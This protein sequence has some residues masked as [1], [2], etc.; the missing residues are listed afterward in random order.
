MSGIDNEVRNIQQASRGEDVRDSIV[1]ALRSLYTLYVS[2]ANATDPIIDNSLNRT[3]T[4]AVENRAIY[5]ALQ[6][7]RSSIPNIVIDDELSSTSSNPLQN[8]EIYAALNEIRAL[9]HDIIIDESLSELSENPVQNKVIA[10]ALQE[11]EASIPASLTVDE[12]IDAT[13]VNPI[14]NSAVSSALSRLEAL[15][16][17]PVTIDTAL[18][19]TSTNPVANYIIRNAL[20]NLQNQIPSVDSSIS[21]SSSNPVQNRAIYLALQSLSNSIPPRITID[22]SLNGNSTNP[23]SN[24][25]IFNKFIEL[26]N[27]IDSSI[28][29][30]DSELDLNSTN[31]VENRAINAA[32]EDILASI[33]NVSG[34]SVDLY[35]TENSANLVES[36]GVYSAIADAKTE[37]EAELTIV[38]D[39]E[40][41]TT[42]TNAVQNRIIAG[43]INDLEDDIMA[44]LSDI[45]SLENNISSDGSILYHPDWNENDTAS[46]RYIANRPFYTDRNG[47]AVKIPDKYLPEQIGKSGAG[48]MAELFNGAESASGWYSHAE[49][50]GTIAIGRA[51][52]VFGA[53]NI[54]DASCI[55]IV[56]NGSFINRSNARTLDKYGN[57]HLSGGI[58]LDT[59]GDSAKDVVT[60][61]KLKTLFDF[62]GNSETSNKYPVKVQ[63]NLNNGSWTNANT[64]IDNSNVYMSDA[65]SYHVNNG[66]S[67]VTISFSGYKKF[68]VVIWASSELYSDYVV[69]GKLDEYYIPRNINSTIVK[70]STYG[71]SSH[72]S[73]VYDNIDGLEHSIEIIYTKDGSVNYG[74]D[75]GYF[76]IDY[77]ACEEYVGTGFIAAAMSKL[78]DDN[79]VTIDTELNGESANPVQNSAVYEAI[80]NLQSAIPIVDNSISDTSVNAVQ[81]KA[82]SEAITSL[83]ASLRASFVTMLSNEAQIVDDELDTT[84]TNPVQN[85]VIATQINDILALIERIRQDGIS[86]FADASLNTNSDNP[87]QNSAVAI[88]LNEI[89]TS[90]STISSSLA[91]LDNY[92]RHIH[93]VEDLV[94]DDYLDHEST[95]PIQNKTVYEALERIEGGIVDTELDDES[96]NPVSNSAV[97]SVIMSLKDLI[98]DN[99]MK[100]VDESLNDSSHNAISNMAVYNEFSNVRSEMAL[101]ESRTLGN[102]LKEAVAQMII[103]DKAYIE[104]VESSLNL[105]MGAIE[106]NHATLYTAITNLANLI[107]TSPDF[108]NYTF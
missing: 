8:K 107:N 90:L 28:I 92:A 69:I 63:L 9:I 7:I 18:S 24:R 40:L 66:Y 5:E 89:N 54:S 19:V 33:S 25:A 32:L 65:Y 67:R 73:I 78:L 12:S 91:D 57:E 85:N 102:E 13:S 56:G 77:D 76:Y 35:P 99:I 30:V 15:I 39:D 88:A 10:A 21:P 100:T 31:P 98:D 94:V 52:H 11:L 2:L 80:S 49:G 20:T 93:G 101:L 22:S 83:E 75:R 86:A 105:R 48:Y 41:S 26:K 106:S 62:N 38:P 3:S 55:E 70:D 79:K 44:A 36:S 51:Q 59:P 103:D 74:D 60:I 50:E 104:E 97:T 37:L 45:V 82:V 17:N 46:S 71:T 72:K 96:T 84:S 61:G 81:N 23:V 95:N 16:P 53:Y 1:S 4:N 43:R 6:S 87:I 42:S 108:T 68:V 27:N 47:H 29:A 58:T 34:K 64:M 14:A